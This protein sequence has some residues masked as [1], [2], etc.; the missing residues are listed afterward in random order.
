MSD[1]ID[2]NYSLLSSVSGV[3]NTHT[4]KKKKQESVK[5]NVQKFAD[6]LHDTT[7]QNAQEQIPTAAVEADVDDETLI[8]LQDAVF[9]TGDML[10]QRTTLETI[11]DYKNAVSAFLAYA[12]SHTYEYKKTPVRRISARAPKASSI[13]LINQKLDQ[14]TR[15]LIANQTKQLDILAR[16]DE[17]KGLIINLFQ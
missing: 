8:K 11:R 5:K 17:I 15:D 7:V 1:H 3:L 2:N 16:I 10:K 14:L 13:R 4:K 6:V 12:V 9:S